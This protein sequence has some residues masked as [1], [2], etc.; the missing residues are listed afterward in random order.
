MRWMSPKFALGTQSLFPTP[1]AVS[2]RIPIGLVVLGDD[3]HPALTGSP[4]AHFLATDRGGGRFPMS[5]A[6][7]H[8][9]WIYYSALR[10][11]G[12]T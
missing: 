7:L 9:T 2:S 1:I 8:K 6:Q 4:P 11:V 10:C 5:S 3:E 12:L